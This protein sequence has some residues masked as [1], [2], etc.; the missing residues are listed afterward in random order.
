MRVASSGLRSLIAVVI[1]LAGGCAEPT[2]PTDPALRSLEGTFVLQS[3]D[4]KPVPVL[5]VEYTYTR[6]FLLAD[7]LWAD[8]RGH[9]T[10][11]T[12][13][14]I[15]SVG[16]TYRS[17]QRRMATGAYGIRGD[18]VDFPFKCPFGAL[19]ISPPVGWRLAD[20]GLVLAQPHTTGF[21]FVSR[22]QRA[23]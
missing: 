11:A 14:A 9:Y 16:R 1:V 7:T 18:T 22:F 8:G 3:V 19:C 13:T 12:I 21:M 5:Q 17:I 20:G 2:D 23:E 4:S 10:R 6:Q 15:D